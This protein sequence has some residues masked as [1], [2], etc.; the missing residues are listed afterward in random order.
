MFIISFS[1]LFLYDYSQGVIIIF[2]PPSSCPEVEEFAFY[3]F[4]I[5]VCKSKTYLI[6]KNLLNRVQN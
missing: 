1:Q 2:L 4:Y 5:R 6:L 3:T